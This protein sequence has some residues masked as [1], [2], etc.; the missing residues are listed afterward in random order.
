MYCGNNEKKVPGDNGLMVL[1]CQVPC[2]REGPLSDQRLLEHWPVGSR[3]RTT[4]MTRVRDPV[5]LLMVGWHGRAPGARN[6]HRMTAPS[7]G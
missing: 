1:I 2:G 3:A 4:H 5:G 7:I 6:L